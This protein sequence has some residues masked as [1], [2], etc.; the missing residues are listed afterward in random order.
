MRMGHTDNDSIVTNGTVPEGL[1]V[2]FVA[3]KSTSRPCEDVIALTAMHAAVFDG[4]SSPLRQAGEQV[5][6]RA[7][8]LAAAHAVLELDAHCTASAAVRSI[9]AAVAAVQVHHAGPHGAVGAVLSLP[10]R[11]IWRV[12]DVNL[13]IDEMEHPGHKAIDEIFTGFRAAINL[14]RIADGGDVTEIIRHDPG[15]AA[16]APLLA[17]QPAF[18]NRVGPFGYGVFDGTEVPEDYVEVLPVPRGS[19]VTIASDGYP[20]P[21]S[22]L[23]EAEQLLR[24]AVADDPA[25][26][27]GLRAMGKPLQPG[28][29][30]PDDRSYLQILVN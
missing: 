30:S 6:G 7:Y 29:E 24:D 17:A 27:L 28:S 11:E 4:M 22:T 19:T 15:L 12:G 5:S 23:E 18:A 26:L 21:A 9:T 14:A 20:V 2:A 8:A 13:R 10:R 16:A 3:G 1:R 25:C